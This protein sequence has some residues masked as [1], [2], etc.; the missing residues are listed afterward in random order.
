MDGTSIIIFL[1][2]TMQVSI[3]LHHSIG[4]MESNMVHLLITFYMF[5]SWVILSYKSFDSEHDKDGIKFADGR[6]LKKG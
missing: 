1:S 5:N 3:S 6:L 2:V 4:Q